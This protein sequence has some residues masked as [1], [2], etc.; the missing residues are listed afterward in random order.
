MR[1]RTLLLALLVVLAFATDAA[2]DVVDVPGSVL[3]VTGVARSGFSFTVDV[4]NPTDGVATFDGTGLYFV[5]VAK[6][7]EPQRLGVVTPG[8]PASQEDASE[9]WSGIPIAPHETLRI[10]LTAY[11]L[12]AS[13]PGPSQST[14]YRLATVR[15]PPTLSRPMSREARSIAAFGHEA[16]QPRAAGDRPLADAIARHSLTQSAVWRIRGQI[17]MPLVGEARH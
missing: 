2:A 6:N 15:L 7:D 9:A 4:A 13:R 11:C 14:V 1:L 5:P 16:E 17:P 3:R 12:D 10:T 8:H